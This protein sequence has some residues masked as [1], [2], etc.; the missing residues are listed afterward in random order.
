MARTPKQTHQ[1]SRLP[2][3]PEQSARNRQWPTGGR[4]TALQRAVVVG[5]SEGVARPSRAMTRQGRTTGG[6]DARRGARASGRP[7]RKSDW[8]GCAVYGVGGSHD[9]VQARPLPLAESS[10]PDG[11]ALLRAPGIAD[12][13]F[14][15][16]SRPE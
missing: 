3:S 9:S 14:A 4:T 6:G 15:L 7:T 16:L 1:R 2:M 12:S 5:R 10:L 11:H 8:A 13:G